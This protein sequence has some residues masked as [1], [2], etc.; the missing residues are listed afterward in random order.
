VGG[1]TNDMLEVLNLMAE[2]MNPAKMV[3]HIGGLNFENLYN[4]GKKYQDL[5]SVEAENYLPKYFG[6]N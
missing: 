2:G 3:S 4:I 6:I 5:W 1:N